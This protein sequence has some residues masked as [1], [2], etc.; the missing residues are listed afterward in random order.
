M[1]W[2]HHILQH[3]T[4]PVYPLTLFADPD[5]L[6]LEEEL[7]ADIR[8]RGFDLLSLEDV[9]AFR[10]SYESAYRQHWDNDQPPSRVLI[11]R[12]TETSLQKLPYDLLQSGRQLHFSL[13]EIFPRLSYP[14]VKVLP[15]AYFQPLFEAHQAYQGPDM[16]DQASKAFILKHV[17]GVDRDLIK[18]PL[19]ALKVLL[20]RHTRAEQVPVLLDEF[21]LTRL[22]QIP[23]LKT[24]PL[25]RLL[26]NTAA[27]LEFLQTQ[28]AA[29]LAAQQPPDL[30]AAHENRS[31][32]AAGA[33]L[34]L[35]DPD[36]R[37]YLN[38][39][40]LEGKLKPLA[41]PEGWQVPEAWA[42][43][44]ILQQPELDEARRFKGLLDQLAQGLPA[45]GA[46]HKEWL[47][48]AGRWA[49]LVVLRHRYA[50]QLDEAA[51]NRYRDLHD[52][53]ETRFADWLFD[54]YHTLHNQPFYTGPVMGHHIPHYLAGY[55]QQQSGKRR[56]ALVVVDGLALDQW[57]IIHQLWLEQGLPWTIEA[58]SLFAWVPTLTS[59]AR[60]AIFSGQPPQFF[61]DSWQTTDQEAKRWQQFWQEQGLPAL[62]VGYSRNLGSPVTDSPSLPE[63]AVQL[64]P[65]ALALIENPA[66]QVL[67][68]V[69]NTVD[70]IAHGMQLGTA[71]MH[72]QVQLWLT[73]AGYLTH[74]VSKL[75]AENYEVFLTAD[76]GNIWAQGIGRPSEGVLVETRGQRARL[77]TDPAFLDLA[78]QQAPEALEWPNIGLPP[79]LR[80]LLAPDLKAFLDVNDQAVC[81]GGIALEEVVVP[82]VQITRKEGV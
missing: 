61:P 39:L 33:A 6:L 19:D 5:G 4:E 66:T 60:Q 16:G 2:R 54:R 63:A 56:L 21:L 67:G 69:V 57:R 74:L 59:I 32:Y 37:V 7:L 17:F 45:A 42:G 28:W 25:A 58:G 51:R 71:G 81:H 78:H 68:L 82:F 11:L 27:F 18:T 3:F 34:P 70:D 22:Q 8:A 50:A 49:E 35:A 10:H 72:Q 65:K 36:V 40:F 64:E 14:V 31:G 20:A 48:F 62:A 77:Y 38:A 1:N 73:G 53:V 80:V 15:P 76:H 41:L 26:Q 12:S 47:L 29:F 24:W 55:R 9:V 79:Q 13:T 43:I 46:L 44:G 75:L 52:E 30:L 23:G